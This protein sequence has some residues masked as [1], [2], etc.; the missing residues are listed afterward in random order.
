MDYR[1]PADSYQAGQLQTGILEIRV[2]GGDGLIETRHFL[3]ELGRYQ[4]HNRR[5]MTGTD[6]VSSATDLM[7]PRGRAVRLMRS[8]G[9]AARA[10]TWCA[11]LLANPDDA[12]AA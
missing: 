12:P 10:I 2:A 1:E 3:T 11:F 6:F 7:T 4:L 9:L 8:L 5:R